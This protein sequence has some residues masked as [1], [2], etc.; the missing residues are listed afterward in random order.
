MIEFKRPRISVEEID[1]NSA[2]FTVEPLERGFGFTLGNCMRRVLLSSLPGAA[3]TSLR[4]DGVDHEFTSI[5]G[6]RED[7]TDIILNI[8]NLVLKMN[9]D[10]QATLRLTAKGPKTVKAGDIQYP[11][12]VEVLNPDLELATLNKTGKI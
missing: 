7:V 6:V 3:V 11:A 2:R 4:I 8:K 5:K 9:G 10:S 12:G 1:G